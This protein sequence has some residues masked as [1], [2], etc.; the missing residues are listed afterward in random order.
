MKKISFY[1]NVFVF[2]AVV[3]VI[4]PVNAQNLIITPELTETPAAE[5]KAAPDGNGMDVL[6][7]P[8]A[9]LIDPENCNPLGPSAYL[10]D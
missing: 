4:L 5:K 3:L 10:T 8:D 1:S 2:L 7:L 6:C 9:Y